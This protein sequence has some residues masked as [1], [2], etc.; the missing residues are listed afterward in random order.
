MLPRKLKLKKEKDFKLIFQKGRYS[1]SEHFSLKFL[2]NSLEDSR[3]AFIV[4][5]KVLKKAVERNKIKR[6]LE[7]I[8]RVHLDQIKPGFDVAVLVNQAA[9]VKKAHQEIENEFLGLLKQAELLS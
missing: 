8:V 9:V 7:E 5:A 1:R 3:F 4:K 6:Q 2:P